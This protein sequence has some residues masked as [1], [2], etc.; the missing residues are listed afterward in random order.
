MFPLMKLFLI[1]SVVRWKVRLFFFVFLYSFSTLGDYAVGNIEPRCSFEEYIYFFFQLFAFGGTLWWIL[2][3]FFFI[4]VYFFFPF[5]SDCFHER[6][7]R[8]CRQFLDQWNLA[9]DGERNVYVSFVAGTLVA[10]IARVFSS[11]EKRIGGAGGCRAMA[12][13][14]SFRSRVCLLN[15]GSATDAYFACVH[16][17]RAAARFRFKRPS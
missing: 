16:R 1:F 10:T 4:L 13:L 8:S 2:I 14:R 3:F 5:L 7:Q 6:P 17:G 12:L 15:I 11:T 9:F